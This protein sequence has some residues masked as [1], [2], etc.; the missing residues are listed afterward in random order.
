[1]TASAKSI[2]SVEKASPVHYEIVSRLV[3]R[4]PAK[5]AWAFNDLVRVTSARNKRAD[6]RSLG[7]THAPQEAC[8]EEALR[9]STEG[10]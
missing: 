1:L 7:R 8:S 5:A 2:Q 6:D 4:R 3:V 9:N 10:E